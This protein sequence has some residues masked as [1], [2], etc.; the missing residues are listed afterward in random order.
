MTYRLLGSLTSPYVRR[1]RLY[2]KDVPYEF[3]LVNYLEAADDAR[4]ATYNP[5][6]RIPV[7]VVNGEAIWESRVIYRHLQTALSRPVLTLA[8]ENAVSAIDTLQ[9]QLIQPFLLR[10]F[11]HPVDTT[12]GYYQRQEA[13]KISLLAYLAEEV[14]RGTFGRWDYPSMSL[15]CLLDWALF[16]GS[17]VV[18]DLSPALLSFQKANLGQPLITDTDPRRA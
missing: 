11:A 15:Y 7:L 2:L 3:E 13:R 8:E 16:R 4:L 6:R 9:D 18:A 10:R 14:T 12:N 5:I 1:L 17:L